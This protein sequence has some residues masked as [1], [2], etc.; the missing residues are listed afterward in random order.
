MQKITQYVI[1]YILKSKSIE[2]ESRLMV[3]CP[4]GANRDS[5]KVDTTFQGGWECPKT[6]LW[7]FENSLKILDTLKTSECYGMQIIMQ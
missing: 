7:N 6:R 1:L 3:V 4:G 5:L 2:E